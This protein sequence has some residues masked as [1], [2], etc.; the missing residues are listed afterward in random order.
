VIKAYQAYSHNQN[1]S[2]FP[3]FLFTE[4]GQTYQLQSGPLDA[5]PK[6]I[7]L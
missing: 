6:I 2:W 3:W 5:E 4:Q 7:A 1:K